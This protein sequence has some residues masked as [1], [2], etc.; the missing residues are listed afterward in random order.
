VIS[1]FVLTAG[2]LVSTLVS[3]PKDASGTDAGAAANFSTWLVGLAILCLSIVC[4]GLLGVL[5]DFS[6]RAY[7]K[8][9]EGKWEKIVYVLFTLATFSS[10]VPVQTYTF[11]PLYQ[12]IMFYAHFLGLALFTTVAGDIWKHV[13]VWPIEMWG[14]LIFN[15]L[16]S[17]VAIRGTYQLISKSSS[18]LRK[19]NEESESLLPSLQV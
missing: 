1:V 14:F 13:S 6:Y 5:Q 8:H 3:L 19:L 12:E 16:T 7:G 11:F 10:S 2:V 4:T 18:L 15:A 9:W 17:F